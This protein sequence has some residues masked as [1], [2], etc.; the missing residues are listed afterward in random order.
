MAITQRNFENYLYVDDN[1][2]EWTKRGEKEAV[3]NALDGSAPQNESPWWFDGPRKRV[4]TITYVDPTT[5]RTKK[6][7]FYTQAA[8]A[9]VALGD[10]AAFQIEGSATA[11]NYT[12]TGKNAEFQSKRQ[13]SRQ[14]ADHA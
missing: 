4:R 5:F 2:V 12:A 14:L 10:I 1:G 3:R 11:V 6:V 8:Y 13:N 7:I 9:A